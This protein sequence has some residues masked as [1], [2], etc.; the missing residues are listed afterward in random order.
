MVVNCDATEGTGLHSV[1]VV[2][3][4]GDKVLGLPHC[5]FLCDSTLN[6]HEFAAS[7]ADGM[8]LSGP[9]IGDSQT[10]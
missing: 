2:E 3:M 5:A 4:Q 1:E 7:N 10:R 6:H 9:N 8:R